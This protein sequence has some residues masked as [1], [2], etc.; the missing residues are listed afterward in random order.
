M[1]AA[2]FFDVN[3]LRIENVPIPVIDNPNEVLIKV[4][5]SSICG[6]D[7]H[8]MNV[9]NYGARHKTI[10]GH[11][12]IGEVVEVGSKV[13]SV[14]IGDNVILDPNLYCGFCTNCRKGWTNQCTNIQSMGITVDGVFAEYVK[15]KEHMLFPIKKD[16]PVEIGV[17]GEPLACAFGGFS[18]LDVKPN[19]TLVVVGCGPI[20]LIFAQLAKVNGARVLCLETNVLRI[21]MAKKLGFN[22]INP[23]DSD[24]LAKVKKH[25][26]G[27]P[28]FVIDAAGSQLP[29]ALDLVSVRGTVLVFGV[30]DR[31]KPNIDA[32]LIQRKEINIK[33][34]FIGPFQF[35]RAVE[36]LESGRLNLQP[37]ITHRLP[38]E[39]VQEGIELMKAGKGMK[40]IIQ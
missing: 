24:V 20:G 40:I 11:E 29:T 13:S 35:P 9:P 5:V 12:C 1:K 25:F 33:G 2:V 31:I 10:L 27:S 34:S 15:S 3:D 30:N 36:M 18:K 22:V 23:I 14:C 21:D 4:L 38:L 8:I 19:S 32:T 28:E 16:I 7:V 6:T 17:F 39:K 26:G 37:I